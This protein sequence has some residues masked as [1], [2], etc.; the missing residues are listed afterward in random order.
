MLPQMPRRR[1]HPSIWVE[2]INTSIEKKPTHQQHATPL[3]RLCLG[4]AGTIDHDPQ[5]L[6]FVRVCVCVCLCAFKSMSYD[7]IFVP[8]IPT[9]A[10]RLSARVTLR[11]LAAGEQ[12]TNPLFPLSRSRSLKPF[13]PAIPAPKRLQS[14][15]VSR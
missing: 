15:I 5:T 7:S 3:D 10:R 8:R 4:M 1:D 14:K 9:R 11:Y 13:A 12:A 2:N 6:P